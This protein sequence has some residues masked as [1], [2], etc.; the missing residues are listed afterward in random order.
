MTQII[1]QVYS[2]QI[3]ENELSRLRLK[4]PK[5]LIVDMSNDVEFKAA[6]KVRTER[7]KLAAAINRRRIDV[8]NELKSHGDLLIEQV[9]EAYDPL[10]SQFEIEDAARKQKAAEKEVARQ[11]V[12][13]AWIDEV[14]VMSGFV[15]S[16]RGKDSK[17]I[18]GT[19]EAVDL[20]DISE[21]HKD[22]IHTAIQTKKRVLREL[23]QILVD[24]INR[25]KVEAERE[26][27]WLEREKYN[28]INDG[29]K[30]AIG[31]F[32]AIE[33]GMSELLNEIEI[34]HPK[35]VDNVKAFLEF[36]TNNCSILDDFVCLLLPE[37][38]ETTMKAI[39]SIRED[40]ELFVSN[41]K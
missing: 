20:I 23:S 17:Y 37:N 6:R 29:N 27:L 26:K 13:D 12:I 14:N 35:P 31:E 16:C 7:N 10:V 32:A 8:T 39:Q 3:T 40:F 25:E 28:S 1:K 18:Q 15:D 34:G 19:I 9:T 4:Y 2:N 24:T 38:E 41:Q 22:V 36:A 30:E 5:N 33:L 21:F 11:K